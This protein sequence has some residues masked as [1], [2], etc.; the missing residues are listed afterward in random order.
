MKEQT[1]ELIPPKKIH[2]SHVPLGYYQ[3]EQMEWR[4]LYAAE[5]AIRALEAAT[6]C[7]HSLVNAEN[8]CQMC[9]RENIELL[10]SAAHIDGGG[11]SA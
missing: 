1:G 5:E 8:V 10:Q 9:G 7:P 6:F 4:H 2:V 3:R 11:D